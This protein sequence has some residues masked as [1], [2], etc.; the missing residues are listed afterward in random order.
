MSVKA[1]PQSTPAPGSES[2]AIEERGFGWLTFAGV[3]LLVVGTVNFIEGVAAIGNAHFF[4]GNT[5][6]VFGTLN[7]WGWVALCIGVIQWAVGLGVFVRNQLARWIGV[8]IL[9][10]NSISALLMMPAY[11]FWSLTIFAMDMLAIYG[12]VAYGKHLAD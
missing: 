11:P 2:Y 5:H 7:T 1:T 4:V 10:L 3:L 12:L 8:A 9:S 6:Y